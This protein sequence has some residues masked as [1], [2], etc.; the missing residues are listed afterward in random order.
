MPRPVRDGYFYQ[1]NRLSGNYEVGREIQE[2]Q[3][4]ME[5][6]FGRD[7]YTPRASDAKALAKKIVPFP[8]KWHP[9]HSA[10]YFPHYHPQ[11]GAFGHIFYGAR[12]EH[13]E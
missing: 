1:F 7:A 5:V 8:P 10:Q 13:F 6:R 3:A 11:P 12:G 2:W 4:Q 9:P